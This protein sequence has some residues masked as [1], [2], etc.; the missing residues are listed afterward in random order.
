MIALASGFEKPVEYRDAP[1][2]FKH[3]L[4]WWEDAPAK[5]REKVYAEPERNRRAE[6]FYGSRERD[7]AVSCCV[8]WHPIFG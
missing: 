4:E 3:K 2:P 1:T 5:V 8:A 6:L 7:I